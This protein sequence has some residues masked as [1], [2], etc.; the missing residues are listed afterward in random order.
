MYRVHLSSSLSG[1]TKRFSLYVLPNPKEYFQAGFDK[2]SL[3]PILIGMDFLGKDGNGLIIDFTTGLVTSTLDEQP[4]I[5]QL[6]QNSKGHYM[7][8]IREFLTKGHVNLEGHAH[9][10]V[11]S[12][13]TGIQ[14]P[15]VHVLEFHVVQFDLT[16]SDME[17]ENAV[18][19]RSRAKLVEMHQLSRLRQ[20]QCVAATS[21]S[22]PA[23][24]VAA[25][26]PDNFLFSFLSSW[27]PTPR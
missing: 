18:L 5:L 6:K 7:L 23:A 15:E 26:S 1:S 27:R 14:Q 12:A 24:T 8:D 16:V 13:P 3:V 17:L 9:V 2:A 19:Q 20:G 22:M 25:C 10:V 11:S 4:E 21:C